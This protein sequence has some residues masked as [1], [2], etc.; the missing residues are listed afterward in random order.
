MTITL[1][2]EMATDRLA[3]FFP[4]LQQGVGVTVQVGCPLGEI[5]NSQWGIPADYVAA[6]ITTIFLNH[7]PVDDVNRTIIGD[8]A[9]IALSGAMPGLVGATMRRGG[10]YGAMRGG[11]THEEGAVGATRQQGMV[12]LKLFNLLLPELGPDFL[13]RGIVLDSAELA[14]FFRSKPAFFWEGCRSVLRQGKLV[15]PSLLTGE[16]ILPANATVILTVALQG[17]P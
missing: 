16:S 15:D 1:H 5:L 6:R 14:K 13:R 12:C 4:L 11:I 9:T 10:Y 7:R 17:V 8:G 2:L 3:E